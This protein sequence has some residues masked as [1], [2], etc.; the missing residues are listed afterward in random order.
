MD[1][2]TFISSLVN[3]LAWPI[4]GLI[5]VLAFKNEFIKLLLR[6]RK[7]KHNDTE[8]E[9]G[10]EMRKLGKEASDTKEAVVLDRETQEAVKY[11]MKIAEISPRSA[12]AEAY[13]ILEEAMAKAVE[14]VY[15]GLPFANVGSYQLHKLIANKE[16]L[17]DFTI[18]FNKLRK[19]RNAAVHLDDFYLEE[20]PVAGYINMALSLAS[21]LNNVK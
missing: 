13:R 20:M 16:I 15:P 7:L 14:R 9:F 18:Q 17:P 8:I 1:W 21:R 4:V 2:K 6:L 3:S 12:V 5:L 11:L 19:L 10:E